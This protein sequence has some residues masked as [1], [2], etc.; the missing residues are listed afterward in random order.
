MA[1]ICIVTRSQLANNPRVVKEA[2]ALSDAGHDVTVVC[3]RLLEAVESRDQAVMASARFRVRRINFDRPLI[4][5]LLRLKQMLFRGL[6][7]AGHRMS[8]D[9]ALNSFT[10][11]MT[12][13]ACSISADLYIAH[14]DAALPAVA[15]AAKVHGALYAFDGEDFHPGDLPDTPENARENRLIREVESRYL[16]GAAF[17]TAASPMI[18]KAF[19]EA[20]GIAEPATIL[21]TF[22][23]ANGPAAPTTRGQTEPGPSLYWFSQTLGPGRGLEAA[24]EAASLARSRPHVFLRGTLANGYGASLADCAHRH[25]MTERLHLLEPCAPGDLEREGASFDLG[26]IGELDET[27]NRQIA[28]TNKLFS[29]LISGIP[30]VASDIPAHVGIAGRM[31][32]SI[33]IFERGCAKSL[34]HAIDDV[35]FD[36]EVLAAARRHA[37]H[38]GQTRFSWESEQETLL[39][40]VD[41]ALSGKKYSCATA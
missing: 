32:P 20:Y 16:P 38:L 35:L 17:V 1:R 28:L 22:P 37:W 14:Y 30:A 2:N 34:A 10:S 23:A 27:P 5:K 7:L 12:K 40:S 15:R 24:I 4:R 26:Y 3:T 39:R 31:G 29:Y 36:P 8:G 19:A 6:W 25:G 33:R 11:G 9:V 18:G 21:N 13:A 41:Q